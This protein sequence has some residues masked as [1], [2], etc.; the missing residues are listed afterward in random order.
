MQV[1]PAEPRTDGGRISQIHAIAA[2][3][4]AHP[5][6]N[7]DV[8][9]HLRALDAV[10][11]DPRSLIELEARI[12]LQFAGRI[13]RSRTRIFMNSLRKLR[14]AESNRAAFDAFEAMLKGAMQS[15]T[16]AAHDFSAQG[17]AR[18]DHAA[19]WAETRALIDQVAMLTDGVF[20]NS[21][22]LLG[23]VRDGRLIDH[24]DDIDLGVLIPATTEREAGRLWRALTPALAELG[25]GGDRSSSRS[26]QVTLR[27]RG[28]VS[29]DLF[30][31][32]IYRG[33]AF[34]YPHTYG[35]LP[36]ADVL[37]LGRCAVTGLH[38]PANPEAMLAVNYG[39]EWREPDPY[40]IFPWKRQ[41][42]KFARFLRASGLEE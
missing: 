16:L 40:F 2:A 6:E 8:F 13:R 21:G 18:R 25:E 32:W 37:P 24:D 22:T 7:F 41:K 35:A 39:G 17:F 23:V 9:A 15:D 14:I 27:A 20:L 5:A 38:I 36:E 29:V 31:A 4:L 11:E 26:P 3:Q 28:G 19:I 42:R 34:V 10:A 12:M 1:V 30:P 33:A